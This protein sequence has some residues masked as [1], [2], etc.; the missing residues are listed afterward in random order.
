LLV[1]IQE[2]PEDELH[3]LCLH[4]IDDELLLDACTAP[5]SL[6]GRIAER[7]Q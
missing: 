3:L 1:A 4:G 5:L 6:D 2:Q 7:R